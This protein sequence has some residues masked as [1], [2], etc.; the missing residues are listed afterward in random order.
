[1]P[2]PGVSV[3]VV[4]SV[5][6]DRFNSDESYLTTW[7]LD[8]YFSITSWDQ[9]GEE[10]LLGSYLWNRFDAGPGEL[11]L[12]VRD[13]QTESDIVRMSPTSTAN[14]THS[15]YDPRRQWNVGCGAAAERAI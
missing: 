5:A 3:E 8:E 1:M 9:N 14:L 4:D 13:Q 11:E 10:L 6:L 15:S 7:N 12:G 2:P